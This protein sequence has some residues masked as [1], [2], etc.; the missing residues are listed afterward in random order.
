MY[1]ACQPITEKYIFINIICCLATPYSFS[2]FMN[3]NNKKIIG[4][5]N[6]HSSHM[7][8]GDKQF[9]K[10]INYIAT[11]QSVNVLLSS[12]VYKKDFDERVT[13]FEYSNPS[14]V[15]KFYQN[16]FLLLALYIYRII[17]STWHLLWSDFDVLISS[18]HLFFDTVPMLFLPKRNRQFFTAIYHLVGEQNRQGLHRLVTANLEK[19]ALWILRYRRVYC[20]TSSPHVAGLLVSKYKFDPNLILPIKIGLD[21][22]SI[23]KAKPAPQK[24]DLV[25]CGRLHHRKGIYTLLKIVQELKKTRPDIKLAVIGDGP[26]KHDLRAETAKR[27]LSSHVK[28]FG[29]ADDDYKYSL[30]KSSRVFLLPSFEEGWGIVIAE[31][32]ACRTPVVVSSIPEIKRIW[33]KHVMWANQLDADSFVKKADTL[34]SNQD[35]HHRLAEKGYEYIQQF[36]WDKVLE[37]EYRQIEKVV[38][39]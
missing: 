18:S 34:L 15:K 37:N 9:I 6:G 13:R 21:I 31:S 38:E 35:K 22:K 7:S 23:N 4:L 3:S 16:N 2:V 24:F 26:E 5:L 39:N 20:L 28:F 12:Q 11:Q 33:R 29:Y 32:L 25:F 14:F 30:I 27:K 10:L 19:L 8:G 17:V 1:R 36:D